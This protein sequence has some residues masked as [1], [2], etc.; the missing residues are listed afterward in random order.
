MKNV[1]NK[2]QV[3]TLS[4]LTPVLNYDILQEVSVRCPITCNTC[5]EGSVVTVEEVIAVLPIV[6][7]LNCVVSYCS[8]RAGFL[9]RI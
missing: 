6:P 4:S 5:P 2:K 1:K 3:M 9:S 8:F 7:H